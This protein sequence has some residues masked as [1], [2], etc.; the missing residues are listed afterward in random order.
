MQ[1]IYARRREKVDLTIYADADFGNIS[2]KNRSIPG[3]ISMLGDC[4]IDWICK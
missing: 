1:L 2:K 4:V 3:I